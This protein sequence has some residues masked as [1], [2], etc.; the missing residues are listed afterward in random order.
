MLTD[1]IVRQN[2]EYLFL[3]FPSLLF[4]FS[5]SCLFFVLLSLLL[6]FFFFVS[7]SILSYIF[8]LFFLLLLRFLSPVRSLS[9]YHFSSHTSSSSSVTSLALI[10]LFHPSLIVSSKVFQVAVFHFVHNTAI[11]PSCCC[12][13]LLHGVANLYCIFLLYLQLIML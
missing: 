13:F 8:C 7:S 2:T 4:L 3:S 5:L 11:L 6:F 9:L 10:D 12:S 1:F